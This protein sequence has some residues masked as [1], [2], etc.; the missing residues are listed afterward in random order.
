MTNW[1]ERPSTKTR[2]QANLIWAEQ[3][4]ERRLIW[5][6]YYS[7]IGAVG[8]NR[9]SD[10]VVLRSGER[11]E[12][13]KVRSSCGADGKEERKYLCSSLLSRVE[14]KPARRRWEE[15][16]GRGRDRRGGVGWEPAAPV[17]F[18]VAGADRGAKLLA[19]D[20]VTGCCQVGR[21]AQLSFPVDLLLSSIGTNFILPPPLFTL[22]STLTLFCY[23]LPYRMG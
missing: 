2:R 10:W 13:R 16:E 18:R 12:R 15:L 5:L 22:R 21:V 23:T 9:A 7:R 19:G 3:E 14:A 11:K 20:S 8:I 6:L 17:N 1:S 4:A